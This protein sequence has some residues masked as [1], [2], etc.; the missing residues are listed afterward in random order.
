M[1]TV[2]FSSQFVCCNLICLGIWETQGVE[3]HDRCGIDAQRQFTKQYWQPIRAMESLGYNLFT[4]TFTQ[5]F[6]FLI[7]DKLYG[8]LIALMVLIFRHLQV[9]KEKS[10]YHTLNMLSMDVTRKC[11]VGE[12]WSPVYA[13]TQV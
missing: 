6:A 8:L 13:S 11:L 10:V 4:V 7:T 2:F 3:D 12:G 1:A 9:K 5:F